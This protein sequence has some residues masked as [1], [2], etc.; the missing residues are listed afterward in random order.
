MEI[1]TNFDGNCVQEDNGKRFVKTRF[2]PGVVLYV[3]GCTMVPL[4]SDVRA[5]RTKRNRDLRVSG[6]MKILTVVFWGYGTVQSGKWVYCLGG[7]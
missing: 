4:F 2:P 3:T 7:I 5:V 6:A 1:H